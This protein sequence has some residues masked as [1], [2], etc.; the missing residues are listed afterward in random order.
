MSSIQSTSRKNLNN[1]PNDLLVKIFKF[2]G[3]ESTIHES[4]SPV[5]RYFYDIVHTHP[6]LQNHFCNS[7]LCSRYHITIFPYILI[8]DL[9]DLKPT[10]PLHILEFHTYHFYDNNCILYA[11]ETLN[12]HTLILRRCTTNIRF[13]Q[14]IITA[15]KKNT[16]IHTVNFNRLLIVPTESIVGFSKSIHMIDFVRSIVDLIHTN[17]TIHTLDLSNIF[18]DVNGFLEIIRALRKNTSIYSINMRDTMLGSMYYNKIS[19]KLLEDSYMMP[20]VEMLHHNNTLKYVNFSMNDISL[21][22]ERIFSKMRENPDKHVRIQLR[23]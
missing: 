6:A 21:K 4:I 10:V 1:L 23:L 17:S 20:F 16:K 19:W 9:Y 15:L 11:I 22:Y 5:S 12:M 2:I 13:I 8:D 3:N 18:L 7:S 14:S